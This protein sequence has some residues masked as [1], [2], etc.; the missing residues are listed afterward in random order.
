MTPVPPPERHLLLGAL[1]ELAPNG[2]FFM[3]GLLRGYEHASRAAKVC[4]RRVRASRCTE[5]GVKGTRFW[6]L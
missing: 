4:G 5:G 1:V 2:T 3:P 6:K